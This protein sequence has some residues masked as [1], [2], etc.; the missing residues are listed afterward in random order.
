MPARVATFLRTRVARRVLVLFL[1]CAML[2]VVV[3]SL[4]GYRYL[5]GELESRARQRLR[6][7][8]KTAGMI[9]IDRLASLAGHLEQFPV[10]TAGWSS[11]AGATFGPHFRAILLEEP[12]GRS[13]ALIGNPTALPTLDQ[14][15]LRHLASGQVTL[16]WQRAGSTAAVFLVRPL[17][18]QRRLWGLVEPSSV[19]PHDPARSPAPPEAL[20]CIVTTELIPLL[21][22]VE[23]VLAALGTAVD[24]GNTLRW[25][26]KRERYVAGSW[27][28]FLGRNFA[29]PSWKVMLSM[30]EEAI[31]APLAA[32]RRTFFLGL[33]LVLATVFALS[34]VHLRRTLLPLEALEAGTDRLA[35]G[36]FGEPVVVESNDEFRALAESFNRMATDLNEQFRARSAL[37]QVHRA[38]LAAGGTAPLLQALFQ[39]RTSLLPGS[40]LTVALVRADDPDRWTVIDDSGHAAG[41]PLREAQ[42][43]QSELAELLARPEGLVV[44]QGQPARSYFSHPHAVQARPVMVLPILRKGALAGALI[45]PCGADQEDRAETLA[46]ARQSADQI[47][48]AI[49]NTQLVEELD[50]MNWG[51]LT[52]LARAVDAVSPWTAGHSERVTIGAVEIARRLRLAEEDIDLIHRGGLLH[53]VGK[54]GLPSAILEKP[55]TLTDDEFAAVRNHPAIGVRILAP[56][57]AF[58]RVLPLVLHHHEMLD[59]SGYPHG[60]KGD[61]IPLLVR[62]L[63]VADVFDALVSD[64]PYRAA[65]PVARAMEYLGGEAGRKF[66]REVFEALAAAVATGWIPRAGTLAGADSPDA[67]RTRQGRSP[68]RP[69][70]LMAAR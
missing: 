51:A 17:A 14:P 56:I 65:W 1:L 23:D 52:A 31:F 46:R 35:R 49:S 39:A 64:R 13:E 33:L 57:G 12:D 61:Q 44:P 37:L 4:Y 19:W 9:L 11:A 48:V 43:S 27:T 10:N 68:A 59:G 32:L 8:S 20:P 3:L 30:P 47:A 28:I 2:P 58:R 66:D 41:M 55:G 62:V 15:R 42:P 53:D 63:T 50:A 54:V 22:P 67:L 7:D 5:A 40:G 60:L 45:L 26:V 24:D 70:G 38:A 36:E 6:A 69:A 18:G 34:H 16:A 29:A 21:C 25:A